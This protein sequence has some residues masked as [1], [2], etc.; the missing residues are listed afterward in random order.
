MLTTRW[1]SMYYLSVRIIMFIF[2]MSVW[3]SFVFY[4]H[5]YKN[6][7]WY[8]SLIYC[9]CILIILYFIEGFICLIKFKISLLMSSFNFR[10]SEPFSVWGH[11]CFRWCHQTSY[12]CCA[13]ADLQ[14]RSLSPRV[15]ERVE[16]SL[17]YFPRRIGITNLTRILR[18]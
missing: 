13:K 10:L 7:C 14:T 6:F 11:G 2:L 17:P 5:S 8:Y 18:I 12:K 3:S 16:F 15:A 9:K 1:Y 4:R